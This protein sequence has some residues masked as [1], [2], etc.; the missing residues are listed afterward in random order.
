MKW[1]RPIQLPVTKVLMLF[2][3]KWLRPIKSPVTKVLKLFRMWSDWDSYP[4]LWLRYWYC[5]EYEVT[6]THTITVTKVLM[7]FRLWSDWDPYNYLW[8]RYCCCSECEV[9]ETH[10]I[11]C[12]CTALMLF[13]TCSVPSTLWAQWLRESCRSTTESQTVQWHHTAHT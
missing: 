7:L 8:L 2:S 11:T 4:Y 6:E 13:R 10:A 5:S 12:D 3:V 9:T 1:L